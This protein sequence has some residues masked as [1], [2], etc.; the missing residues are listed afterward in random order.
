LALHDFRRMEQLVFTPYRTL[1]EIPEEAVFRDVLTELHQDPVLA[2]YVDVAVAYGIT[3][4]GEKLP[5]KIELVT[6]AMHF[7]PVPVLVYRRALLLALAGERAAALAQL[8]RSLRVYPQDADE[9][10]LELE[11]LARRHPR[12]FGPL[13]ELAAARSASPKTR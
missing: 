4:S 13:L 1:A 5:E 11:E 8:E 12:E 10:A 3:V 7:A 2:P 6:R 9:I